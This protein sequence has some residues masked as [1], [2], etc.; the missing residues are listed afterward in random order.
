MPVVKRVSPNKCLAFTPEAFLQS[1]N[2]Y[3]E[4][5]FKT[6]HRICVPLG[7]VLK[8]DRYDPDKHDTLLRKYWYQIFDMTTSGMQYIY[9]NFIVLDAKFPDEISV[10]VANMKEFYELNDLFADDELILTSELRLYEKSNGG[11]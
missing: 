9:Q 5:L 6:E 2:D 1:L 10:V 7:M 8:N 3:Q 4:D 11:Q